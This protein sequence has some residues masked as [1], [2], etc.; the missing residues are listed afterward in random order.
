M[1]IGRGVLPKKGKAVIGGAP[2]ANKSFIAMNMALAM[3]KGENCFDAYYPNKAPVMPVHDKFKILYLEQEIGEDGLRNRLLNICQGELDPAI[4]LF[5]K[6][7]DLS[8]RLDSEEGR[9]LIEAEVAEVNPDVVIFDPLAKFH[10][11]DENSNQHMGAIMRAGDRIVEK[12]GSALIYVHHTAKE[13]PDQEKRGGNRLRGASAVFADVDTVIL[14]DR[15]GSND[16]KEP[17]LKLELEMRRGEP[18]EAI[19]LRRLRNGRCVYEGD[20]PVR[21]AQ[22]VQEQMNKDLQAPAIASPFGKL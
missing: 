2:K 16:V 18:I 12:F 11:L 3:A 1:I 21:R 9:A 17:I 15:Q 13:N 5:I 20:Q 6:S 10:L 4:Q 19:Y 7:R 14:V 8:L 22:R